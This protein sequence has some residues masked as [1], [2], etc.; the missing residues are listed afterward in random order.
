M[1]SIVKRSICVLLFA[2]ALQ[3]QAGDEW[4]ISWYS[5]DSGGEIAAAGGGWQVS[6]TIGQPDAT[7]ANAATGGNWTL[8]GG[9][10]SWMA[11]YL[12]QLFG[13]RFEGK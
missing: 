5:I 9:F 13:D 10:W 7:H 12:D 1:N 3:V 8:T 6:G 2:W 4:E 11:E